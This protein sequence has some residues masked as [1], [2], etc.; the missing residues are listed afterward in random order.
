[1][2]EENNNVPICIRIS[3]HPDH[4]L[5]NLERLMID[6]VS[7]RSLVFTHNFVGTTTDFALLVFAKY[8]ESE[9]RCQILSCY[10]TVA[11]SR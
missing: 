3:D 5:F 10:C 11:T 8:T 9:S 7:F 4:P 1:M 6:L 2:A